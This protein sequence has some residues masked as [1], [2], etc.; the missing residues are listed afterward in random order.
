MTRRLL[1]ILVV[2][3]I[4]GLGAPTTDQAGSRAVARA[5]RD[6][7]KLFETLEARLVGKP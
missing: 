3:A 1:W 2:A 5:D 6:G 7:D 4:V